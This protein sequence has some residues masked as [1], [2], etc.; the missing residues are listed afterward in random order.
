MDRGIRNYESSIVDFPI[1][2]DV[3]G[4]SVTNEDGWHHRES[5][6]RGSKFG[7]PNLLISRAVILRE[8][9]NRWLCRIRVKGS[10]GIGVLDDKKHLH[11]GF[12][13]REIPKM[14]W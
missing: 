8:N 7:T 14:T 10:Q 2:L 5:A 3:W 4:P 9:H 1:T 11:R 6:Y 12:A 13:I